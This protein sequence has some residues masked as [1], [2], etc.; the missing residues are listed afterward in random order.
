LKRLSLICFIALLAIEVEGQ[1]RVDSLQ[2]LLSKEEDPL[3]KVEL[4]NDLSFWYFDTDIEKANATT[5]Q[6]FDLAKK[7]GDQ[8]GLGW[9]IAYRGVYYFLNGKLPEARKQFEQSLSISKRIQDINLQTYS[10]TQ[11]GNTFRDRGVYDSADYFYKNAWLNSLNGDPYYQAVIKKNQCRYLLIINKPDSALAAVQIALKLT[12]PLRDSVLLADVW[13]LLGH[14]YRAK[15]DFIEA[16]R[17]YR[18]AEPLTR[19]DNIITADYLQSIGEI[20]FRRGDF[21]QTLE[22]WQLVLTNYRKNQYKYALAN[23]LLRMGTVFEEQGYYELGTEY[24][25]QALDIAEKASYKHLIGRIA[26]EQ[27]WIYFRGRN[28]DLALSSNR[29]AISTFQNLNTMLELAGSWDLRGLVE[30]HLK[31]FDSSIYYHKK[32]LAER[33]RINNQVD[34]SAGSFN[35]GEYYLVREDFYQALSYY[36]QSLKIDKA[37]GDNYGISLNYNRIGKIYTQLSAFDSAKVYLDW[38]LELAIPVSSNDVLRD[39]YL[40]MATYYEK[41]G[42]PN[43]AIKYYKKYNEFTD[44][45]FS[46]QTAQSLASYRTLYDVERNEQKISLL[47]KDVELQKARVQ[48]QRTILYSVIGGS[49]ILLVL[50]ISY[51]QF[52]KKL[53]RLNFS[54]AEQNELIQAQ[55]EELLMSNETLSKLNREIS[56]QKE[57]IQAQAEELSESNQTISEVNEQLEQRIEARTAELKQAFKELDTFFYRSS[58]DFRRPLTTF[59]GLAEVARVLVKDPAALELFEKV[60]ENALNLDKMLRKLQ[61]ISDVGAQELIYREVFLK[62]IFELELANLKSELDRKAIRTTLVVQLEYPFYSYAAL[63]KIIVQNLLENAITFSATINPVVQIKAY[64]SAN[65][66]IIE[67]QDNGLGI[68]AEYMDRVFEMYFRANDHSKGNGLG[69][70]I[71]KKTVQKLRGRIELESQ[72]GVGTTVRIFLPHKI[73]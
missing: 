21:Q 61:S 45:L 11:L 17:Y 32:S 20:Y 2:R 8:K 67:I 73:D 57:E 72:V 71:V 33:I 28:F 64:N 36:F 1:S 14:C 3:K 18:R 23:L 10:L 25:S 38:S 69:L 63:I 7:I 22:Y 48:K 26:H 37:L 42:R 68:E 27:S 30:R 4:L 6:A 49:L 24:L 34:I 55:S 51:Y 70:Y 59:M 15:D 5:Q 13:I 58:H 66:V 9:A 16:E 65:E 40:G 31:N 19:Y 47:S 56:E 52:Y 53:K 60:N 35:L 46:K 41:L 29:L 54:L 43:E 62:D 39:S 50:L 44:S 12:E